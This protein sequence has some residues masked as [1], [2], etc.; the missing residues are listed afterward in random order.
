[1]KLAEIQKVF[2]VTG[3]GVRVAQAGPQS[4]SH[5]VNAS[6][7]TGVRGIFHNTAQIRLPL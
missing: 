5:P 3:Q 4:R 1:M 6:N 7:P 2:S